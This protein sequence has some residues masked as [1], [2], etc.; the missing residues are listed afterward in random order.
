MTL[1]KK[2][3]MFNFSLD[4]DDAVAS[5]FKSERDWVKRWV[6]REDECIDNVAQIKITTNKF[7]S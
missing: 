1:F 2:V 3:S 7:F 5:P 6:R 4:V